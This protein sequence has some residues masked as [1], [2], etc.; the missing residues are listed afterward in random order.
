MN[1]GVLHL[2]IGSL[3]KG[4]SR[5]G[6]TKKQV[7]EGKFKYSDMFGACIVDGSKCYVVYEKSISY[8]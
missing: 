4:E 2:V 6:G 7:V 5:H 8:L 1:N 3:V